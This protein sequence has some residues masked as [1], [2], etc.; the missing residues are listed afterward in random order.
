MG[1]IEKWQDGLTPLIIMALVLIAGGIVGGIFTGLVILALEL[2][3]IGD[4]QKM[5]SLIEM[6]AAIGAVVLGPMFYADHMKAEAQSSPKIE[7][8]WHR[9]PVADRSSATMEVKVVIV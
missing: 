2:L 1:K 3:N 8:A 5:E 6:G 7:I 4:P 9:Y